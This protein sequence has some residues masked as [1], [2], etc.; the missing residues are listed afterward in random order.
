MT[1]SIILIVI[2]SLCVIIVPTFNRVHVVIRAVVVSINLL[3][4][5][6]GLLVIFK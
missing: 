5:I 6:S 4:I 2:N 1:L 3:A